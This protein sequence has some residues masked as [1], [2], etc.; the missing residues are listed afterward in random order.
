MNETEIRYER[1][2]EQDEQAVR[3]LISLDVDAGEDM[4][5]VLAKE[6]KW[7]LTAR[8]GDQLVAL[9]QMN[10]PAPQSYITVFVDPLLRRQG[11]GTAMVKYMESE[12]RAG[13]TEK[14]RSSFR[15]GRPSS[16]AFAQKLG[17]DPYFS[18]AYMQRT[19]EPF[20]LE[21]IPARVY[22]DE[23]YIAS[24]AFYA[25]AFHDM[26]VRVGRFPDS[27]IAPPSEKERRLWREEAE[28]RF[29]YEINGEIVAYSHISGNELSSISVRTDVQGRGIGR[30]FTRYLCN[31]IYR[32]GHTSV[33]LW[34][35]VGNYARNLYD[36][37][38]F[39]ESY[40]MDL[41]R[42]TL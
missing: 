36:S 40:T 4:L 21:D 31:E 11:I 15:A 30:T 9:G 7:F 32:R 33:N 20:P 25:A 34:C 29:V 19:G 18:S 13:G 23:D 10:E 22:T 35:V 42:K 39:T 1:F 5:R 14:V 27:V 24:Q 6:P 3:Q 41:V 17:F 26:R 8:I 12:L 28:D 37:L 2:R 16:L 38:G